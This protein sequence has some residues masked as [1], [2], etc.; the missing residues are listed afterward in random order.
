MRAVIG[1][2]GNLGSVRATFTCAIR[3]LARSGS[4]E[5]RSELY[6]SAA[7][8]PPQPP[9]LNAAV[10]L[11]TELTPDALLDELLAIE[12]S[13]GRVRRER[14]GAR[15]LDLDILAIE[16]VALATDRL[17][18]PHRSLLERSF[19]LAPLADVWPEAPADMSGALER[20]GR[21]ERVEWVPT[22]HA[23]SRTEI[24][25]IGVDRW[26]AL[27]ALAGWPR[28]VGALDRAMSVE[29]DS[30]DFHAIHRVV[31]RL[32]ASVLDAS[33]TPRDGGALLHLL[34]TARAKRWARVVEVEETS[35]PS[36]HRVRVVLDDPQD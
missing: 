5:A 33:L 1:L 36:A 13:L 22:V 8:G 17:V 14:W 20:V 11:R 16:G 23:G 21:P 25:A 9:Y 35:L 18:V 4:I 3:L 31:Q 19:A 15:T 12:R 34:V 10:L 29:L 28:D 32:G 24:E 7:L 2:G 27:A 30:L 26:D 6:R